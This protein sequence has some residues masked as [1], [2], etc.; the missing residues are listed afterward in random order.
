MLPLVYEA[1][2]QRVYQEVQTL[3]LDPRTQKKSQKFNDDNFEDQLSYRFFSPDNTPYFNMGLC[4]TFSTLRKAYWECGYNT[5]RGDD[6][7]QKIVA[8]HLD[9]VFTTIER[10]YHFRGYMD[11][12]SKARAFQLV[13]LAVGFTFTAENLIIANCNAPFVSYARANKLYEMM[14]KKSKNLALE[15]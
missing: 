1:L 7:H 15:K 4:T 14:I 3:N 9:Y 11:F 13:G 8:T 2:I 5:P 6:D 10:F 12:F